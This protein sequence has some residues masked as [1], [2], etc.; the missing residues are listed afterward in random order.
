MITEWFC[1]QH[2]DGDIKKRHHGAYTC[3]MWDGPDGD[4]CWIRL[5]RIVEHGTTDINDIP[6]PNRTV[7]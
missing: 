2:N 7:R 6:E 4:P 1:F 5:A 3:S